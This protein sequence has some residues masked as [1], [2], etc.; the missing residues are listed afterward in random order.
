M[1]LVIETDESGRL[2]L[3]AEMLGDVPPRS[4][5]VVEAVGAN[6]TV[7]PEPTEEQRRQAYEKWKREWDSLTEEITAAWNTDQSAAE[8]IAEMRG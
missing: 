3:P 4:R 1:G 7:K 6:L 8:M 2:V 5:F